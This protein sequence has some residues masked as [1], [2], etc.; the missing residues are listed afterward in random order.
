MNSVIFHVEV[1]TFLNELVDILF[2]EGYFGFKESAKEYVKSLVREI[3]TTINNKQKKIAPDYFSKYGDN[4][5]YSAYKRNNNTTWYVF[6]HLVNGT[7]YIR[8]IG[9]NHNIGQHL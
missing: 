8:F 9:N 3:I 6:F 1:E 2:E 7:Y 5:R 4:L